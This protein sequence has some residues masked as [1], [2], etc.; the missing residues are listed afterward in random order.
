MAT[1]DQIKAFFEQFAPIAQANEKATGVKASVSLGQAA[2]ESGYGQSAPGFNFFGVKAGGGWTGD[3][4]YLTTWEEVS[5]VKVPQVAAFRKYQS[6]DDAFADHARVLANPLYKDVTATANPY[7][8]VR[9]IK[10]AG[11][12]TDSQ[13]AVNVN[14]IIRDNNLTA[15]DQD[16][17]INASGVSYADSAMDPSKIHVT[18]PQVDGRGTV[19]TSTFG[20]PGEDPKKAYDREA[21]M[22]AGSGAKAPDFITGYIQTSATALI[23]FIVVVAIVA[24]AFF[25]LPPEARSAITKGAV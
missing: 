12:A 9:S 10:A 14:A 20:L 24:G 11:Y 13:Y 3:V 25:L 5:G 18:A 22:N 19:I 17:G 15:Y 8:Q 4:Q 23:I 7:D 16:K 21:A 1:I 6:A 2:Q